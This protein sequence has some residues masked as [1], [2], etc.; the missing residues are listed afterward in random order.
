MG[1]EAVELAEAK[2]PGPAAHP[3][4]TYVE[5][6]AE[7]AAADILGIKERHRVRDLIGDISCL[8]FSFSF[9]FPVSTR[10]G[11]KGDELADC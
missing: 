8:F 11:L 5:V 10:P 3:V 1:F 2:P 4:T 6:G 7:V 9:C